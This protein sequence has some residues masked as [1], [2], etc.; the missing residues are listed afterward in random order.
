MTVTNSTDLVSFA[1][2][3]KRTERYRPNH[4]SYDEEFYVKLFLHDGQCREYEFHTMHSRD[5]VLYMYFV[6][7]KGLWTSYHGNGKS[8]SLYV[9][10]K[11]KGLIE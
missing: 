9:W 11:E 7:N 10:M 6:R 1:D 5:K 8:G 4:P 3:V 2:A